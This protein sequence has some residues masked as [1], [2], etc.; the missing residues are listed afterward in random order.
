MANSHFGKS[1]RLFP[2]ALISFLLSTSAPFTST[3]S[4]LLH[5]YSHCKSIIPESSS[6]GHTPIAK[7]PMATPPHAANV[8]SSLPSNEPFES[9]MDQS[10]NYGS[11]YSAE[12]RF[13]T[14][15][16][17]FLIDH[18][19]IQSVDLSVIR[20][21]EETLQH[22]RQEREG[23]HEESDEEER[24]G[25]DYEVTMSETEIQGPFFD[26]E[27]NEDTDV[28]GNSDSSDTTIN[29]IILPD[30][31]EIGT[32]HPLTGLQ[33]GQG[34]ASSIF[35]KTFQARFSV[36]NLLAHLKGEIE[37]VQDNPP[38]DVWDFI[39]RFVEER[40]K[41]GSL[42][43]PA[44][45]PARKTEDF[46][47]NEPPRLLVILENVGIEEAQNSFTQ[48]EQL[49]VQLEEL[50]EST[51][52]GLSRKER[53]L[54][55]ERE[56]IKDQGKLLLQQLNMYAET[57]KRFRDREREV[58]TDRQTIRSTEES[59]QHTNSLLQDGIQ[60][61]A[62]A[63][64]NADAS[65]S[66]VT[67][68]SL[69]YDV[70]QTSSAQIS[71]GPC[72]LPSAISASPSNSPTRSSYSI[73]SQGHPE[74]S[75]S[76]DQDIQS[77]SMATPTSH[78]SIFKTQTSFSNTDI[79]QTTDQNQKSLGSPMS[80]TQTYGTPHAG[81]PILTSK[82]TLSSPRQDSSRSRLSFSSLLP[83]FQSPESSSIVQSPTPTQRQ[84]AEASPNSVRSEES[85]VFIEPSRPPQISENAGEVEDHSWSLISQNLGDE[86]EASL[87]QPEP[88][89]ASRD[90]EEIG[91]EKGKEKEK[92]IFNKATEGFSKKFKKMV[93]SG[94][95]KLAD[96]PQA[97]ES[98]S[99]GSKGFHAHKRQ[100]SSNSTFSLPSSV[101]P[102]KS[103]PNP[104]TSKDSS[105]KY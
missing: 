54:E 58:E 85:F 84:Q 32:A 13:M 24:K 4:K 86:E 98:H 76:S 71:L 51:R 95:K 59:L 104:S 37:K 87:A 26:V 74:S 90:G 68:I 44:F 52:I 23:K 66:L 61:Q 18:P 92:S 56:S 48:L 5:S 40:E 53:R 82:R 43:T 79:S 55:E 7:G 96:G 35:Q 77:M 2:R 1:L 100:R 91:G 94:P 62:N 64:K 88:N 67:S 102:K 63:R 97:D 49:R 83:F 39:P 16:E 12:E 33:L 93:T 99:K 42:G 38:N 11:D 27:R 75:L 89:V 30:S 17:S 29:R 81:S 34:T 3:S 105:S 8:I 14:R 46:A 50:Q 25:G 57:K 103:K 101:V 6:S 73:A 9:N 78:T 20:E 22:Q 70:S 28:F 47:T 41:Q 19:I 21:E 15:V 72:Q 65:H 69:L 10:E 36:M 45:A 60:Q 31:A 80:L